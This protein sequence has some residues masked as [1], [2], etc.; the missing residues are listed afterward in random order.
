MVISSDTLI[1][2]ELRNQS[3]NADL[4]VMDV[5]NYELVELMENT[6]REVGD[7]RNAIIFYDIR[8]YHPDVN[9][10]GI[11]AEEEGVKR[12]ALTH[13][14]PT[15]PSRSLMTHYYVDPIK[16]NYTGELFADGDGTTVR[17]PVK[18]D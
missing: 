6:F 10:I 13:F 3:R 1:T 17:I 4:L 12:M 9:D 11:M 7:E 15:L 8:E 14:A 5:M 18:Q 16:A 2:P